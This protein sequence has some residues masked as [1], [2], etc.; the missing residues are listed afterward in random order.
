MSLEG[1]GEGAGQ[2]A[3]AGDVPD[4]PPEGSARRA[5]RPGG[6]WAVTGGAWGAGET[7]WR[8]PK[9]GAGKGRVT[10]AESHKE[11]ISPSVGVG[12]T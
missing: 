7:G 12:C 9:W 10:Q 4:V 6:R 2:P 11:P 5:G 8:G 3:D 1:G